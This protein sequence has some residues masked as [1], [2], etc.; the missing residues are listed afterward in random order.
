[1]AQTATKEA[2]TTLL[3]DQLIGAD[4]LIYANMGVKMYAQAITGAST[5]DFRIMLNKHL[6]QAIAFQEQVAAF[7]SDKGWDNAGDVKKQLECDMKKAQET[8][9]MLQD[10]KQKESS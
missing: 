9:D 1:M 6:D 8:M 7:V 4:L 3:T 2:G 5:P 10:K